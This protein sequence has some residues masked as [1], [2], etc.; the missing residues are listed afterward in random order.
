LLFEVD[1]RTFQATFDQAKANLGAPGEENAQLRV[2]KAA[3]KS[4]EL[5]L[6]FAQVRAPVDGYVTNLQLRLGT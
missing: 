1:P 6:E 5:D 4:A 3:L 2:A